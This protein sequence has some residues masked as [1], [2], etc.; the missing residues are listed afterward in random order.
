M[1]MSPCGRIKEGMHNNLASSDIPHAG[2]GLLT[3]SIRVGTL[4]AAGDAVHNYTPR[5]GHSGSSRRNTYPIFSVEDAFM[6]RA[7]L[8]AVID[9][10]GLMALLGE[11]RRSRSSSLDCEHMWRYPR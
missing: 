4:A 3:V 1:M 2:H 9:E 6:S 8:G 11:R 5:T 7:P 10:L